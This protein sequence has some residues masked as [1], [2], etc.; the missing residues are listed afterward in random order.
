MSKQ[1]H[2]EKKQISFMSRI[3]AVQVAVM[4]ILTL[5]MVITV[6]SSMNKK[7]T[8]Q[9][10]TITKEKS[11]YIEQYIQNAETV[12]TLYSSADE[13]I[14][15]VS[16]PSNAEYQKA[17][18]KYTERYSA[19]IKNLEGIYVS[20][21]NTHVLAHTEEKYVGVTTR[22]GDSLEQ[23]HVLIS[24]SPDYLYNAGIL[25]SPVSDE[26]IIS[27][28]KAVT[29][30][31]GKPLGL[32]GLGIY[33]SQLVDDLNNSNTKISRSSTYCMID[34]STSKYIFANDTDLINT[35]VAIPGISKIISELSGQKSDKDD[36]F[37]YTEGS[38]SFYSVYNYNGT[39]GWLFMVAGKHSELF[40]LTTKMIA[41]LLIFSAL[42]IVIAVIF[43]K[44]GKKQEE[45]LSKLQTSLKKAA[46]T[47]ESLSTAV[48]N[49]ILTDCKNRVSFSNDFEAG[50]IQDTPEYPYYFM[51][52]NICEFSNI[53]IMY[54]EDIGDEVLAATANTIRTVIEGAELYRTGSDEFVAVMQ[55]QSNVAGLS[56]ITSHADQT[57]SQLMQPVSTSAGP[58]IPAYKASIVKKSTNI[59]PSVLPALKDIMNQNG[60]S[61]PGQIPFLDMDT[62]G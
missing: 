14:N 34:T 22:Q 46:R 6:S 60:P 5:V 41:F 23:L 24:N 28:Y 38:G 9:C 11:N 47:K 44:L 21:W 37:T 40:S 32:V 55:G 43:N 16:D 36:A 29:D 27:M 2:K 20:E 45:T 42:Y 57:L 51:M 33:T 10:K 7:I 59:D 30:S 62:L 54:G 39:R 8:D 58:V 48:F 25:I 35:E 19:G 50:N 56:R 3:V 61:V 49:D 4:L 53:N 15:V 1:D 52:F 13:I 26:Q 12:L 18:Q 17:A 31:N